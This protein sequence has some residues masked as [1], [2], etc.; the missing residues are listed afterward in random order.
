MVKFPYAAKRA[1][2]GSMS[3]R[4]SMT[5]HASL[6]PSCLRDNVHA[7]GS[8]DGLSLAVTR[9]Y[10]PMSFAVGSESKMSLE[11]L[12]S[13]FKS[14]HLLHLLSVSPSSTLSMVCRGGLEPPGFSMVRGVIS[15]PSVAAY[16][17]SSCSCTSRCGARTAEKWSR[18]VVNGM[19]MTNDVVVA[20]D[21]RAS[22]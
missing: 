5:T 4:S 9:S 2:G 20:S 7:M 22:A 8:R 10:L 21:K 14:T 6:R 1:D 19:S 3:W 16:N 17:R 13:M 15:L 12:L 11:P 18:Y